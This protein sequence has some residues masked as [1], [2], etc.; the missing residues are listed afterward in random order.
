MWCTKFIWHVDN[1][2]VGFDQSVASMWTVPEPNLH[3]QDFK[4][5]SVTLFIKKNE[6]VKL[7]WRNFQISFEAYPSIE[8]VLSSAIHNWG[9]PDKSS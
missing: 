2:A 5:I 1:D 7:S 4:N 8:A 6:K 3:N 9:D